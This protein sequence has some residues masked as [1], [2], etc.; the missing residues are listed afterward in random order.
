MS[1]KESADPSRVVER[2]EGE[3]LR[4]QTRGTYASDMAAGLLGFLEAE[5]D[6]EIEANGRHSR[7]GLKVAE[8]VA[9]RLEGLDVELSAEG[10]EVQLRRVGG[11][12]DEFE[13][14]CELIVSE[15]LRA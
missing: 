14:L 15:Y 4:L 6:A 2:Q 12:K 5:L 10:S 8:P 7:H 1:A 11:S 9:I 3:I 13:E